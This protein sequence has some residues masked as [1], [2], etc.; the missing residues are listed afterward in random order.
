MRAAVR[1][2]ASVGRRVPTTA[3]DDRDRRSRHERVGGPTQ[4]GDRRRNLEQAQAGWVVRIVERQPAQ[5]QRPQPVDDR[6]A[7]TGNNAQTVHDLERPAGR[8]SIGV[9]ARSDK[10]QELLA[11]GFAAGEL[12]DRAG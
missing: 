4:E 3:T 10:A 9:C 2:P 12:E 6:Q 8:G 1:R 5:A 11:A 7:I